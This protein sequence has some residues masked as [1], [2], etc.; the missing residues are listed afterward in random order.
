MSHSGNNEYSFKS[1]KQHAGNL[2]PIDIYR[3]L[4]GKKKFLLE[5]TFQHQ[6]K[7]KFSF[8]GANPYQ[9]IIGNGPR[10]T[11]ITCEKDTR[12]MV[13][14][15]ALDYLKEHL[16]K[17]ELDFHFPFYG[18]AVGYIGYDSIRLHEDIGNMLPDNLDMPDIHFMVFKDIIVFDHTD[19]TI[20]LIVLNHN[21]QADTILDD[22]LEQLKKVLS[23]SIEP[24][25]QQKANL[26]F[27]AEMTEKKFIENVNIAKTHLEQGD[28]FQVVLSQRFSAKMDVDPLSFYQKLREANP[29][30][31]MFYIDFAS[32]LL[33]GASPE[34]LVQTTGQ[35]I[36]TNP[37]AGTRARGKSQAEDEA[38]ATELLQDE[39]EIAEHRMLVDL[40]RND[41][42]RVCEVGS[43]T[44]PTYMTI[45]KYQHVMHIVSEVKGVLRRDLSSIDAL[46]ACLPAGTVSGA[47]KIRAMQLINELEEKKRGVYG[48]GIGFINFNHDLNIALAIR[49]LVIKDKQAILQSGAGIVY[50]SD[51]KMEYQ[52]TLNKAKSIMEVNR[53]DPVS[54]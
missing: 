11:V 41:L 20:S 21:L 15:H 16:P 13:D 37:I 49:S 14:Q 28:V 26:D 2:T 31:Y 36:V 43:I 50:D 8:I 34:S 45:E 24:L 42:G 19:K 32:Y 25:I 17:I 3:Q 46:I 35:E 27:Q 33:L 40:S 10:T 12:V 5:S 48:G 7:G 30:P 9:E 52:E 39:K 44:I 54:R 23:K 51:A 29:S 6:K 53:Y 18:G 38:L 22:R 1:T 4:P 47:P